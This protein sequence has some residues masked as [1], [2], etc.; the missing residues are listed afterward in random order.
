[1][2]AQI[3]ELQSAV[4]NQ[5]ALILRRIGSEYSSARRREEFL[6]KAY[7]EQEMI[8]AD[9]SSKAIR[10]GTLK[11]EVDSSRQLYDAMLER[12]K[13]AEL[14]T[15]MRANNVLVIDRAKIPRLPYRPSL[16]MNAALGLF[17][18]LSLGLGLVLFR[19]RFDRRIQ[20]PGEAYGYLNISELG[21]ITSA[22]ITPSRQIGN[23]GQTN[24]AIAMRA[25]SSEH[26]LATPLDD[27]PELAAWN[28][29]S[30]LSA[31]C[32]RATVTSILLANQ[33][34]DLPR[35]VVVTSPC[36]GDGKTT[37]ASNLSVAIAELGKRVLLV[38]G[39]L[40]RPRLHRVFG[41]SN[42]RGL[43]NALCVDT[44]LGEI[45]PI[46]RLLRETKISGLYLL[47][48]G[49]ST[50][51]TTR[52]LH[53]RRMSELLGL[54]RREFDMVIVDAPPVLQLA[55]ARVLGHLADG[56]ILVIRAGQTTIESALFATERFVKDGT[57]VLGTILNGWDPKT[58]GRYGYGG[59]YAALGGVSQ[60]EEIA[61]DER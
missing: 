55:D 21:V 11:G 4:Q 1:V 38:D 30:S 5:R 56:V 8:V 49:G 53:S 42:C 31:D 40:R 47:P 29:K 44:P 60:R 39:D 24:R 33:N 36:Q 7:T 17:G 9:Q 10:Y 12:V 61:E 37:V 19:E 6:A 48:A 28:Q 35:V 25:A 3:A 22:E 16:P 50:T 52:L 34:G 41:L 59:Y 23:N 58:G 27:C 45:A 43:S 54:L 20:S 13:Q 15:T 18:G 51:N 57:R 46:K 26:A 14:A 32:Y 2:Q